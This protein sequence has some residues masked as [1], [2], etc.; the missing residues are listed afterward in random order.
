MTRIVIKSKVG[1]DGVLHLAVP[2]GREE[3]DR[4]V[5]IT[6]ET[7]PTAKPTQEYLNFLQATAGAWQG[8][9]ERPRDEQPEERDP[10]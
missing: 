10:F 5:Q 7:A 6:I 3:A 4:E 9:F 8:D 1:A 2:V